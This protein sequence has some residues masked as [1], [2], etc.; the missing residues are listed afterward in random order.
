MMEN[1]K[2]KGGRID[3]EAI[4]RKLAQIRKAIPLIDHD[5]PLARSNESATVLVSHGMDAD[6]VDEFDYAVVAEGFES[7]ANELT[8]AIDAKQAAAL[9]QSLE[10]Y[11][12]AEELSRDPQHANLIP[13]VQAMREAYERNYGR[14]I[15]PRK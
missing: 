14:A 5:A 12:T 8:A 2:T 10:V 11:Y 15:P 9:A 13:H 1:R 3:A 7:L 4:L 6:A